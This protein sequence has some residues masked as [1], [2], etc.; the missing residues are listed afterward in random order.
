M[1]KLILTALAGLAL[2][3][4]AALAQHPLHG[5]P[6]CPEPCCDELKK[7][8]RPEVGTKKVTKYWYNCKCEDL[9]LPKCSCK[10]FNLHGCF[11]KKGCG[12]DCGE[13]VCDQCHDCECPRVVKKLIKYPKVVEECDYKCVPETIVV[14]KCCPPPCLGAPVYHPG[15]PIMTA[16]AT[17]AGELLH[18]PKAEKK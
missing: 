10:G 6:G 2:T 1:K 17:P 15:A 5:G 4:S 12:P 8:C 16:P 13:L 18:L 9:C 7:I 3:A 14:P 11:K